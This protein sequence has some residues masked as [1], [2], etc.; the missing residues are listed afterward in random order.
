MSVSSRAGATCA[1]QSAR[2]Y[3]VGAERIEVLNNYG[4]VMHCKV[5]CIDLDFYSCSA[6]NV[7]GVG[8]ILQ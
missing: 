7:M 6:S 2:P 8:L 4:I 1:L 3:P 5:V